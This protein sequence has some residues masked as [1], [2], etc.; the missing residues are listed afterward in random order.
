MAINKNNVRYN[1]EYFGY[2]AGFPDGKILI[3]RDSA[4]EL[5][6][7]GASFEEISAHRLEQL[8]IIP[9]FHLN[10]PPLI[11]LEIT[12]KCNLKCP[13]C[14]IDGGMARDNELSSEEIIAVIDDLA[15]MGVWAIAITGGEPTL[16]P[17]FVKF[18][19][20]ARSRNLL[21]GIATH[22]LHLTDHVIS[23]LP[24]EGVIVSISID[25]LHVQHKNPDT[26]FNI[27]TEALLRCMQHGLH[28][29]IM[30]TTNRK[31]VDHLEKII[32]WGEE[33]NVSVRSVP[34]SPIGDRAKK[35][36]AELENVP[37]D[38]NKAARF[39][40]KEMAWEHE[41]HEKVGLC[42]GLIF[43]YGLTLA[44]MS[45][46]C[47]SGRFLAYICADGTVY[48]CTMCAGENILSPGNLREQAFSQLWRTEWPIRKR[49]WDDFKEACEGCP[50]NNEHYYCSG[51]CP[52]MSHARNGNYHSC[53]SSPF[54]K[55]SLVVRTS[56]LE[57]F[58]MSQLTPAEGQGTEIPF[59]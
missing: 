31:N 7:A 42:V 1:K 12:R 16:H 10:T 6:A 5:L 3:T 17:D 15:D 19:Q 36:A 22:G 49:S 27:A 48:P 50:L 18:V 55:L 30:T 28:A 44:Y 21:V 2:L 35:Y 26:E 38:V 53:G 34:F 57:S 47:S 37:E 41:Y 52:A 14:Y 32:T 58:S 23:G 43:N 24:K 56:L 25:D 54:E 11:W 59:L 9:G 20:H 13:H 4:G 29:N 51:R 46:R 45:R 33:H 40:L 8:E 39:W